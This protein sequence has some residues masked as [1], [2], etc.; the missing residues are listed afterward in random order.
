MLKENT[1]E[2]QKFEYKR[3][4]KKIKCKEQSNRWVK[5]TEIEKKGRQEPKVREN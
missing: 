2:E 1:Q 5:I 4:K 3:K